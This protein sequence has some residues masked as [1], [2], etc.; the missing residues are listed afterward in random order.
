MAL[1]QGEAGA[2]IEEICRKMGVSVGA[3]WELWRAL[4]RTDQRHSHHDASVRAHVDRRLPRGDRPSCCFSNQNRGSRSGRQDR[5]GRGELVTPRRLARD[6]S[7]AVCRS[8]GPGSPGPPR[9]ET[10]ARGA[11]QYSNLTAAS[12]QQPDRVAKIQDLLE[13]W[14]E[15]SALSI[16]R[17]QA[18]SGSWPPLSS[19]AAGISARRRLSTSGP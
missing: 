7:P 19:P 15:K 10:S 13:R 4:S 1:R 5:A 8:P 3:Q 17:L 6:G 9:S 2:P 16:R 14:P 12:R 11:G 18:R